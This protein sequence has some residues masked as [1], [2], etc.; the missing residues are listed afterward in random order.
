MT[1]NIYNDKIDELKK[2][3]DK[4]IYSG[5]SY[6]EAIQLLC[7]FR[8]SNTKKEK[9]LYEIFAYCDEDIWEELRLEIEER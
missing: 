1:D 5:M 3:F 8:L 9:E 6:K 7:S 2:W 4:Q